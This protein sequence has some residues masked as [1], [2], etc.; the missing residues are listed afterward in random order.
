M[1]KLAPVLCCLVL[2]GCTTTYFCST[3]KGLLSYAPEDRP[4]EI[5]GPVHALAWEWVFFYCLPLGS[6]QRT[7]EATLLKEAQNIGADAIIDVRFHT[8]DD[9]D[10]TSVS[11]FGLVGIFPF[12]VNTRAYHLSGLAIRYTDEDR[13]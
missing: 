7:A 11:R 6:N 10:E 12:L 1:R 2:C 4:F 8:E 13:K 5:I 9:C 3:C